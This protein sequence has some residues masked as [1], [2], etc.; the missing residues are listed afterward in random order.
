[1]RATITNADGFAQYIDSVIK[2]TELKPVI[3]KSLA[4]IYNRGKRPGGTPFKT[5]ELRHSLRMTPATGEAG[6]TKKYA[7]YVEYGHR[8]RSGSTVAGRYYL[9]ANV[10]KQRGILERDLKAVI[11]A[12]TE[13]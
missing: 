4:E 1:M 13:T 10:D 7:P 8:T 9:K 5:G 2:K 11:K 6:Y 3:M 12:A